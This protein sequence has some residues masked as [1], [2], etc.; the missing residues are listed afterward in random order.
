MFP[1]SYTELP[2]RYIFVPVLESEPTVL[3]YPTTCIFAY[4]L[5]RLEA[6]I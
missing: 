2:L 3:L 6:T 1:D 5:R 4:F